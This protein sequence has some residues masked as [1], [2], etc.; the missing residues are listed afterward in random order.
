MKIDA[1]G[2]GE[3]LAG[4]DR[5]KLVQFE[6]TICTT[7]A[8]IVN[9]AEETI[10]KHT[11]HDA[12]AS[13]VKKV[14]RTAPMEVFTTNYDLLFEHAFGKARIPIFDG[15]VGIHH[16]FFFPECLDGEDK[17]FFSDHPANW[18]TNTS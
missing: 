11:P 15:F 3:I 1:I 9:L 10:P 4:L 2:K 16:P 5:K 7:I 13:L 6:K 18:V 8:K 14:N 17:N 12:F